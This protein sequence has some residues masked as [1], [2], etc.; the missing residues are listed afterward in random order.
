MS[1]ESNWAGPQPMYIAPCTMKIFQFFYIH[2][3]VAWDGPLFGITSFVSSQM[4]VEKSIQSPGFR[5][6]ITLCMWC[7]DFLG[8]KIKLFHSNPRYSQIYRSYQGLMHQRNFPLV[9]TQFRTP[10][11]PTLKFFTKFTDNKSRLTSTVQS[12]S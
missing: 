12:M 1:E 2:K 10:H 4:I 3:I 6:L 5:N 11:C 9:T 7:T 8:Q